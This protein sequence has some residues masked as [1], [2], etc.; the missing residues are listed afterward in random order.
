MGGIVGGVI[1]GVGSLLGGSKGSKQALAGFNYLTGQN[2]TTGIV[3][4][5]TGANTMEANLLGLNGASGTATGNQALGDYL[6]SS[7][8]QFAQQQGGRAITGNA[9]SRGLL[10]SGDTAKALASYSTGLAQQGFGNYLNTLNGLTTSG[11]N[12]AGQIGAAGTQ[13]GSAAGQMT[14][15]GISSAGGQLG[16]ALGGAFNYFNTPS[17]NFDMSQ[18]P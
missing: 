13:G 4:N 3:N 9:A 16:G 18:V 15:S 8:Y 17:S 11:V 1:G 2:G 5:A 7:G 12:A 10:N 14:Q 6:N